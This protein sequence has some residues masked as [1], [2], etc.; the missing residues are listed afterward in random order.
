VA[1]IGCAVAAPRWPHRAQPWLS[2]GGAVVAI[3]GVVLLA[4]GRRSLGSSFTVLPRPHMR[5]G[6]RENGAY[7]LVRHPIYGGIL[8]LGIGLSLAR[9]PVLFAPTTVLA[10][11]FTLKS[12]REEAWLAQTYAGYADYRARTRRRFLPGLL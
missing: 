8:L 12:L 7:R 4:D 10:L 3:A 11:I 9:S 5:G 2:I 6:L 1:F